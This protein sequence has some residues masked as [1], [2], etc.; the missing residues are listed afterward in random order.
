ME[1]QRRA[2]QTPA[3]IPAGAPSFAA[4]CGE[5][6][7]SLGRAVRLTGLYRASHP[8]AAD[9]I[10]D[11]F[12]LL[13]MAFVTGRRERISVSMAE[14]RWFCEGTLVQTGA[15][16]TEIL[17]RLFKEQGLR[18]LGFARGLQPAELTI[19][20]EAASAPPS[21]EVTGSLGDA[22]AR[23]GV[24]HVT[25]EL[26]SYVSAADATA[27]PPA[28]P[29][30][31]LPEPRP[32]VRQPSSGIPRPLGPDW[33]PA[34]REA[35]APEGGRPPFP[36]GAAPKGPAAKERT[37]EPPVDRYPYPPE[38]R[39]WLP[40]LQAR[41]EAKAPELPAPAPEAPAPTGGGGSLAAGKSFGVLLKSLVEFAVQDP[42]ER[43]KLFEDA[44]RLVKDS[45]AERVEDATRR[46][47]EEKERIR[48]EQA[49]TE[50]VIESVAYGKVVV[51]KEGKVLMMNPAAEELLGK[52]LLELAGRHITEGVASGEHMVALAEDL[53]LSP[54]SKIEVRVVADEEVGRA[55]RRSVAV[56]E[57]P[58]GRVVGTY[59]ALPDVVKY[60]E[61]LRL[62]EEFLSRVTHDLQA[63]LSSITCALELLSERAAPSLGSD[64]NGFIDVCLRNSQQ[65]SSMIR[66]ILDFSKL[67]AGRMSIRPTPTSVTGMLQEA[68]ESLRPWA[69]NKGLD[70]SY[71]PPV[72]DLMVMADHQRIVQVL[73]NLISNAIKFTPEGGRIV[74]AAAPKPDKHGHVVCAVRDTGA[75]IPKESLK[76]LFE[77]FTQAD[78]NDGSQPGVGL[79]LAL[80]SE[81]IRL[82]DGTVWVESEV[83]R[84]STFYF[85]LPSRE[86]LGARAA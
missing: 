57:D 71:R 30:A 58:S 14:G 28:A 53:G 41:P 10:R 34:P 62:Q 85:T 66:E 42:A 50:K 81:F 72:P 60:K 82:H 13:D 39:S 26:A 32:A 23:K 11:V 55:L 4:V 8:M 12:N 73:T 64:E 84:G 43:L 20:C 52:R 2:V 67:K 86:G 80:V 16:S 22:L 75:G 24:A 44:A 46:L 36:E 47:T 21:P 49:R 37:P 65:L 25:V 61:T 33:R 48:G 79:G 74:V 29:A 59:S 35:P 15:Q 3:G 45:I 7:G 56:V 27:A 9:S 5:L 77:K 40:E 69:G 83:G 38:D 78:N 1:P 76:K 6:L 19:F 70:L 51:D 54:G 17:R 63:P 68:V 31:A 18:S